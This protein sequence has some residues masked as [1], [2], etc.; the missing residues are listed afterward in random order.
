MDSAL[1]LKVKSDKNQDTEIL[2]LVYLV[3]LFSVIFC[4]S[5]VTGV[6]ATAITL[7]TNSN[8]KTTVPLRKAL[9]IQ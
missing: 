7:N 4:S 2:I 3:S 1:K 5:T 8:G 6:M 9:V